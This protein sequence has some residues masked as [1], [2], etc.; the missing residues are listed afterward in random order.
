MIVIL[1]SFGEEVPHELS[2]TAS[3]F[4]KDNSPKTIFVFKYTRLGGA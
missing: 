4:L 1:L 3:T 2:L